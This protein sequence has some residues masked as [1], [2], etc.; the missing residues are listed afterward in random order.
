MKRFIDI[1]KQPMTATISIVNLDGNTIT[2]DLNNYKYIVYNKAKSQVTGEDV[3]WFGASN[4]K[5]FTLRQ[6]TSTKA[7]I[8]IIIEN[9]LKDHPE[10]NVKFDGCCFKFPE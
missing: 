7:E 3:L 10:K 8:N 9:Y 6:I 1:I 5:Q 2:Y 4:A